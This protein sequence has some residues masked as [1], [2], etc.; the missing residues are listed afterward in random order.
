MPGFK[1]D[2]KTG[3]VVQTSGSK[4][5]VEAQ[6]EPLNDLLCAINSVGELN[7]FKQTSIQI[8]DTGAVYLY[9]GKQLISRW[10]SLGKFMESCA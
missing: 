3:K 8:F 9:D 7:K 6:P 4:S 1:V 5:A 2:D 10:N